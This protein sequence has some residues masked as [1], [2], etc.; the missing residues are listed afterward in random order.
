M[1][2]RHYERNAKH[3]DVNDKYGTYENSQTHAYRYLHFKVIAMH[4]D[5]DVG[6]CSLNEARWA[7]HQNQLQVS[8][9]RPLQAA[10]E[11]HNKKDQL[12]SSNSS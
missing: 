12:K 1:S 2:R 9:E 3:V 7:Q 10:T 5:A 11:Q 6:Y 8:R 4:P